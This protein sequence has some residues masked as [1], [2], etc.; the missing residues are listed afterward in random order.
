MTDYLIEGARVLLPGGLED[1]AVRVGGGVIA[2]INAPAG[3]AALR[4]DGRGRILA[5]ALVDIHGD[6]FERQVMPRPGVFLPI[7]TALIDTDRQLAANGIATA[8]HAL[9]LS[10]EP[11]LRSVAQGT[12]FV[13]GLATHGHRLTVDHRVQLR[14]ETFAFEAMAMIE[15]ALAGP[16]TPAI[17]FNDHT[18]M[19]LRAFDVPLQARAFEHDPAFATADPADPRLL[20]RLA[21]SARRAGMTA[22]DYRAQLL[23]IW[24]RRADVPAAIARIAAAGQAADAPMLS[25]DDSQEA[26]RRFYRDHGARIAEFP[27]DADLAR[28][29][30]RQGDAT[31]FGAPNVV[32]GGSHIGSP[33]AAA[34]VMEGTGDILASDYVYPAMLAAVGRMR[35]EGR[36]D[37]AR[38]WRTVSTAPARALGLSDR[39]EIREGMR[40]DLVLL[41]WPQDGMPAVDLTLSAGRIA[42]L[43]RDLVRAG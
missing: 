33:D 19:A 29:A 32:R 39:G 31:V 6:A 11:G 9:T 14:W 8:Y 1:C 4:I 38:L 43:G 18:S 30:R 40:A 15:T 2:G 12:R 13:E 24:D 35:R 16:K 3:R 26:T 22:E 23:E 27:M 17:A 28:S 5:P 21:G 25:H 34:M 7:E 20:A 37:L 41:D 10:W 36:G 42:Y